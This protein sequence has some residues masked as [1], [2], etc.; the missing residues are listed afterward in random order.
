M[1]VILERN[2][3]VKIELRMF[4]SCFIACRFFRFY[5][6]SSQ[7]ATTS[8]LMSLLDGLCLFMNDRLHDGQNFHALSSYNR[9]F[10]SMIIVVWG[11]RKELYC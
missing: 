6:P 3:F 11:L 10:F 2:D 1:C 8:Y 7:V 4:I 5:H 9:L